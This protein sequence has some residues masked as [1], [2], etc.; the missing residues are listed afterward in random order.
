MLEGIELEEGVPVGKKLTV[1]EQGMVVRLAKVLAKISYGPIRSNA[2]GIASGL[3][4]LRRDPVTA[5]NIDSVL[6]KYGCAGATSRDTLARAG[7]IVPAEAEGEYHLA[8]P[9]TAAEAREAA[10]AT[11]PAAAEPG[12]ADDVRADGA[13]AEVAASG[14]DVC[15]QDG[16]DAALALPGRRPDGLAGVAASTSARSTG[17]GPRRLRPGP[18]G[19]RLEKRRKRARLGGHHP[20]AP[21]SSRHNLRASPVTMP[22]ARPTIRAR[23]NLAPA[24][25]TRV[26]RLPAGGAQAGSPWRRGFPG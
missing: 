23:A 4:R 26:R 2:S 1:E 3:I 12:P 6:G 15:S 22:L 5:E 10:G 18:R 19:L 25:P 9:M 11:E 14:G 24:K 7:V 21:W 16:Q 13:D 20:R 17:R 8:L